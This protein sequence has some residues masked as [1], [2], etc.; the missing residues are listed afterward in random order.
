MLSILQPTPEVIAEQALESTASFPHLPSFT[1]VLIP[2][3]STPASVSFHLRPSSTHLTHSKRAK[4]PYPPPARASKKPA[5]KMSNPNYG[6]WIKTESEVEVQQPYSFSGGGQN[7]AMHNRPQSSNSDLTSSSLRGA[8]GDMHISSRSQYSDSPS[9]TSDVSNHIQY[10][11]RSPGYD[12]ASGAVWMHPAPGVPSQ[13]TMQAPGFAGVADQSTSVSFSSMNPS[14]LDSGSPTNTYLQYQQYNAASYPNSA[15]SSQHTPPQQSMLQSP[16]YQSQFNYSQTRPQQ[17]YLSTP[18]SGT[19]P[20]QGSASSSSDSRSTHVVDEENHRLRNRIREL[21]LV[22]ES[23]RMRIRELES[24]LA[25]PMHGSASYG[26]SIS[27]SGLPSPLPTPTTP[28]V[29]NASWKA[30]TDAR[31]KMLCSLNRAGN[32]LCAWHDTRRERRAYP[33]RMAPPGHLNCGCSYEEA[34]FE[35]S[36]A[37]HGVGSYHPG[38]NVRMDPALRNPLLKLL[39]HRFGYKD[40]DFERDPI[41]GNWVEGEG[42]APWEAK[43][44]TGQRRRTDDRH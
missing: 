36:L 23:A 35:E 20:P 44:L 4:H 26:Q 14:A 17:G 13:P 29:F 25:S 30:R 7:I 18:Q 38:E 2:S 40:G 19:F 31:I 11:Q 6:Q 3:I 15:A 27:I 33:P 43:A 34:L 8:I 21:E 9:P 37:R 24:E 10:Q 22:S 28:S 32:A 16:S 5:A 12:I 41:T 42:H 39:Q 1:P